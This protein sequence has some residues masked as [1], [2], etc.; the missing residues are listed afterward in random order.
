MMITVQLLGG[1]SLRSGDALLGGPPTQRHRIALLALVVAAWPQPL[2]RDRAMAFLW[3][4]RDLANARRLLNLAVHVLRAA[5]G[6]RAI[7]STG[8]GLLLK[9]SL[10]QCDLHE[11]RTAIAEHAHERVVQL[12]T[13]PLLDGFHLDDSTEFGYWLDE[14]R[15]ELDHAYTTAL[16]TLAERQEQSGDVHGWVGTC[17]RLVAADPCSG[18]YALALMGALDAAGARA[19]AIQHAN[20]HAQRMRAEL[21]LEPDPEVVEFAEELRTARV[22]TRPRPESWPVA[23]APIADDPE[24]RLDRPRTDV[25]PEGPPAPPA[26]SEP[27]AVV[28]SH[29]HARRLLWGAAAVLAL[30]ALGGYAAERSA[31]HAP[32]PASAAVLPFADLSPRHDDGYFS[33]GLT[34]ELITTLSK[35]PGLRVAARTSSFQFKGRNPDVHEVGRR[36]DVGAVL[37][38]SVRRSGNRLRVSAALIDVKDGY[39]LWSESYDRDVA[40][41]FAVQEDVARSIV[42]ALR[43]RLAPRPDS[44]LATRPTRDL[45]AY[46]LYLKGLFAWNQ[47]TR[48]AMGDAVGYLERAVARDSTFVRAWA[49][50][51]DAY[52][53]A[54]PY[55]AA[56]GL[57]ADNWQ[58]ARD[59]ANRALALDPTSAEAYTA[60]GY[61]NMIYAWNWT[62]AEASFR[63]AFAIDPN[64]AVAHHWYGDFLAGRG[65]HAESLAQFTLAHRLDPLSRQIGAEWGWVSYEM[66]RNDEAEAH[67]RQTLELDPN[68]AHGHHRLGLVQIQQRRYAEAIAS[69]K[70]SIDLGV[71]EPYAKGTLAFA[72]AASGDR[73]TALRLVRELERRHAAHENVPPFAIAA[74]YAGLG[75]TT[76]GIAWLLRGIDERD[77]Y[78]PENL[79]DPL[80]DPLRSDPEFAQ[81]LARMGIDRPPTRP[82]DG[83]IDS[84]REAPD[85]HGPAPRRPAS[86]PR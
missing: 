33:D 30:L 4:E 68:Y 48:I 9:P 70:R 18:R 47:R 74:G 41:I 79:F 43:V 1:A 63:R 16:L 65:R 64:Y 84:R 62:A 7:A 73:V 25:S 40:D 36:L 85:H 3:P 76:R 20:E 15:N 32:P 80:L 72:Y 45:E 75:D 13:G 53:L 27:A 31:G 44:A 22:H 50:L 34:D 2:S 69:I 66:Q 67:I 51:A 78:L 82:W 26:A 42:V 86:S 19:A 28:S 23:G 58:K 57:P 37:E 11:L 12:Y 54:Y 52:L 35:V 83:R 49:T 14:H 81:V 59:A 6:E 24:P 55:G 38:G 71:F 39:R 8:D 56:G 46:D 17:R 77:V 29:H 21:E 61:G 60:L 5:I 10:V